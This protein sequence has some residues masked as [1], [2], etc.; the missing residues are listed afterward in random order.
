MSFSFV[1]CKWNVFYCM[2]LELQNVIRDILM[3]TKKYFLNVRFM[4]SHL[5]LM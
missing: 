1:N 2:C 3:Y 4:K 5:R